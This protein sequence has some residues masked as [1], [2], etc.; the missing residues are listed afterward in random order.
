MAICV[1]DNPSNCMR[2]CWQDGKLIYAYS[3]DILMSIE[4]VPADKFFFG[5]NV[6]YWKTGQLFGDKLAMKEGV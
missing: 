6:G 1:F 2:E 3:A 4:P 5:A